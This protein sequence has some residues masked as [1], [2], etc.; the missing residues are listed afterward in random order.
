M[1][2]SR[3]ETAAGAPSSR[4]QPS[5]RGPKSRTSPGSHQRHTIRSHSGSGRSI[6]TQRTSSRCPNA[7][8]PRKI[9][10]TSTWRAHSASSP[11]QWRLPQPHSV[12][13][14]GLPLPRQSM[15]QDCTAHRRPPRW[16]PQRLSGP[17]RPR[18]TRTSSTSGERRASR[19]RIVS[20]MPAH[21][22]HSAQSPS[23][24]AIA[25]WN[26]TTTTSSIR[27]S[28]STSMR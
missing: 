1:A 6:L 21:G 3:R 4:V 18:S 15:S 9:T 23:H 17:W 7:S 26:T 5:P 25:C 24:A 10:A 11:Q 22:R 14:S 27:R 12:S 2:R 13:R 28:D 20:S 16:A 8:S 19:T